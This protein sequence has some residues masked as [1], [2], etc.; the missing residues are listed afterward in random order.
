MVHP[1]VVDDTDQDHALQF[2]HPVGADLFFLCAVRA[3]DRLMHTFLE[4]I[5]LDLRVFTVIR[6]LDARAQ[7]RDISAEHVQIPLLGEFGA[8]CAGFD[9]FVRELIRHIEDV[10]AQFL[11]VEYP[12]AFFVNQLTL[13]I[14]H[15]VILQDVLTGCKVLA[16]HPLLGVLDPAGDHPG[17][18]RFSRVILETGHD[19][20]DPVSAKTA[21]Q[22]VIEA[23]KESRG[24]RVSLTSGTAPELVV[25]TSGLMA[26]RADDM[27][28]AQFDD[29]FVLFLALCFELLIIFIIHFSR[30]QEFFV[31]E[32]D[33]TGSVGDGIFIIPILTHLFFGFKFRVAAQD[34][35]RTTS[36]HVG[37]DGDRV[38]AACFRD[39][40]GF[41]FVM[42]RVQDVM[43]DSPLVEQVTDFLGFFDGNGTDQHR[44][45]GCMHL[46]DF[47][48][49]RLQLGFLVE[50]HTVIVIDTFDFPVGRDHD[51]VHV[52]NFTEFVFFRLG[53]TG[54]PGQ[55]I[56]HT[57]VV[58]QRDGRQGLGLT[59]Y[60][61][62][63]LGFDGLVEPVAVAAS[64]HQSAGELIDDDDLAVLDHV[65]HIPLHDE[66][67]LQGL[68][69]VVVELHVVRIGEVFDIKVRFTAGYPFFCQGN[70]LVLFFDG[71]IFVPL[72]IADKAV[73][74]DVQV[75]GLFPHTG[76]N[77]RGTGFIDQDGV[78][79]VDDGVI[80]VTLYHLFL[81]IHHII[82][83][84]IEAELV[85]RPIRDIAV[86]VLSPFLCR[87]IVE[88]PADRQT[89]E[90]IDLSHPFHVSL[91]E[92]VIDRDDMDAFSFQRVQICR[93]RGHQ[94][95]TFT[96]LHLGDPSLVQRDAADD[97]YRERLHPDS[98][99]RCFTADCKSFREQRIQGF[100]LSLA[101]VL[102]FR[103]FRPQFL[104]CQFRGFVLKR[105][106]FVR[107]FLQFFYFFFIEVS[108]KNLH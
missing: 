95:L 31:L 29:F 59:A 9:I 10:T 33:L 51:N 54:H 13:G 86:V 60:G 43:A 12:A 20:L 62:A 5:R 83:Q 61:K 47:F 66:V 4:F 92:I 53:G 28:S 79:L 81:V 34:D 14:D 69:D 87:N 24:T 1:F 44:T 80:Q 25:D 50:I 106:D 40:R 21:H 88:N 104:I 39:D 108:K 16:F 56:V 52:V 37:G 82:P 74:F 27:Q 18:D 93:H 70:R 71:K 7:A 22:I 17:V 89:Q 15:V 32:R 73:R 102:E 91:R 58:L 64:L 78:D 30:G 68:H 19:V 26:L 35:I 98:A 65:V 2:P 3:F 45:A 38:Q 75:R 103:G 63:F 77:Q 100:S 72:H 41:A 46:H 94:R 49:N 85:V 84:I 99:V 101:A 42:L 36:G 107:D 8:R 48:D 67:G 105:E 97:L 11:A 76:N 55:L 96:G 23:D 90:R 6:Q 57:E